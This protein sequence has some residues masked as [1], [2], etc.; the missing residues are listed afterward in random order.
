MSERLTPSEQ[1]GRSLLLVTL[2][3]LHAI[4][5]ELSEVPRQAREVSPTGYYHI[6]MRGIDRDFIYQSSADKTYLVKLLKEVDRWELASYC[7]MDNHVHLVVQGEPSMLCTTILCM[8][9]PR[10]RGFCDMAAP[11]SRTKI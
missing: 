1:Q 7:L 6:M 5:K 9:V 11:Y 2:H 8:S 3:V 4:A 10:G